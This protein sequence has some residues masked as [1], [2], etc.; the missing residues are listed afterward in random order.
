MREIELESTRASAC[1]KTRNEAG[2]LPVCSALHLDRSRS[3]P[4]FSDAPLR[5]CRQREMPRH[6]KQSSEAIMSFRMQN[7]SFRLAALG[8]FTFKCKLAECA[9]Q[10]RLAVSSFPFW[11]GQHPA[12]CRSLLSPLPPLSPSLSRFL[13]PS[14]CRGRRRYGGGAWI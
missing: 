12:P 14:P 1:E 7:S 11:G 6:Q 3:R 2:A 13:R 8:T 4:D 5:C 10:S 9:P